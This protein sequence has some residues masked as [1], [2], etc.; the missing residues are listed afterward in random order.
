M[1]SNEKSGR[2]NGYEVGNNMKNGDD[3]EYDV[4]MGMRLDMI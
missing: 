2:N 1:G 3:V 4:K